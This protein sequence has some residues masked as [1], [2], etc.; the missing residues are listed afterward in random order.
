MGTRESRKI[1]E[2]RFLEFLTTEIKERPARLCIAMDRVVK[3]TYNAVM[4]GDEVRYMRFF[5][6]GRDCTKLLAPALGYKVSVAKRTPGAAIV[7]GSNM[8]MGFD[9]LYRIR[10]ML[11][12][13]GMLDMFDVSDY[14]YQTKEDMR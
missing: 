6:E 8:D 14:T 4:M 2:D 11:A 12:P 3:N 5:I 13:K 9:V 10:S 1:S 7:H